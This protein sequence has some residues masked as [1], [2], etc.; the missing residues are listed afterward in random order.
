MKRLKYLLTLLLILLTFSGTCEEMYTEINNQAALPIL[1]PTF[2]DNNV[3]RIKL[4]NGL[5]AYIISDPSATQS[6]AALTVQAGSWQ[7]PEEYP[8]MAHLIEHMLFLGTRKYPNES[9]YDTF[10]TE[11][12]GNSNAYTEDLQTTYLFSIQNSSFGDALDRFASFFKEPLFNPS[13][14]ARELQA[15]DQEYAK[16]LDD[17]QARLYSVM[18]EISNPDHPDQ[19]FS[20]GNSSTLSKINQN[21]I[22]NWYANH[23]SA[24]LMKLIVY[25]PLPAETLKEL[26][27]RDFSGVPDREFAIPKLDKRLTSEAVD[28]HMIYVTPVKQI[29]SL[30]LVWELPQKFA[31]LIDSKPDL[32]VTYVL[33]DESSKS[34]LAKL[35]SER[36]A[37]STE[38]GIIKITSNDQKLYLQ[39]ELTNEGVSKINQVIGYCFQALNNL[40]KKGVPPYLFEDLNLLSKLDYQYPRRDDPFATVS[41]YAKQVFNENLSTFPERS[42]VLQKFDPHAIEDLLNYLTPEHCQF[43]LMAP[44]SVTGVKPDHVEKWMRVPY[45]IKPISE[46]LLKEWALVPPNPSIDLPAPNPFLPR[47]LTLVNPSVKSKAFPHPKAIVQNERATVYYSADTQYLVPEIFCNFEIKSPQIDNGNAVQ[48]VLLDLYIKSVK[49]ALN[50]TAYLAQIGKL[51][52]EITKTDNNG[53]AITLSGY[54]EKAPLLFEEILKVLKT[55]KPSP[56]AFQLYKDAQ[57]REYINFSKELSYKQSQEILKSILYKYSVQEFDKFKVI[58]SI[59]YGQFMNFVNSLYQITFTEGLLY[60]NL[61]EEQASG[62]WKNLD[63]TLKSQP[64]PFNNRKQQEIVRLPTDKGPFYLELTTKTSG[65]ATALL[66]ENPRYTLKGRAAQLILTQAITQPFYSALRTQQQTGYIV[67]SWQESFKEHSF[68]LFIDQSNTHNPRDLL[69]RFELEIESFVQ[70]IGH[71]MDEEKF[72]AI[73]ESVIKTLEQSPINLKEMGKTL[74]SLAFDYKADFNLIEEKIQAAQA[75]TYEECLGYA[76]S[77]FG[78]KNKQRLA[79]LISGEI[80]EDNLFQYT[81]IKNAEAL[82]RISQYAP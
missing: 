42:I 58:D 70:E 61:T 43:Y 27:L 62:Y 13:G 81:E 82:R 73:K 41:S 24:N 17:D 79:I 16:N 12:G 56:N 80:P 46:E 60:G 18:K 65:N 63:N 6:A 19:R 55:V 9:E 64:F 11:N 33:G 74:D 75:L 45:V 72:K 5:E 76:S 1:S 22:K 40:K 30:I 66:I 39:I 52:Y 3:L 15:I 21:T 68:N 36:L 49:E 32:F 44:P 23:Y 10:V 20:I 25:S 31:A 28:G 67:S 69:A 71:D 59:S 4:K 2:S 48:V 37:E 47:H 77:I 78:K 35:K 50:R 34:L 14:L 57:R 29:N 51:D 8:G 7:D 38:S 26:V 53:L 54:S